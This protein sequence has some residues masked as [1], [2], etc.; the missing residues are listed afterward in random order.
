MEVAL[1]FKQTEVG[2]VPEDWEVKPISALG[3]PVRGASP[4]PAGDPRYFD[5]SYIPW[6]T[7]AAL[8][9]IPPS[10]LVVSKTATKLTEE[11][12]LCSRTLLPGTLIIANSGATLGVAKILGIKCCANDGI[13]AVLSIP[14]EVSRRYLVYFINTKTKY[15]REVVASGNGQPNLNTELIGNLRIPLPPTRAEQESIAKVLNDMDIAIDSLE[16]LVLKK[17]HVRQ[18]AMQ[19]LLTGARRLPA[20]SEEWKERTIGEIARPSSERNS[21]QDALTVLACSK[22]SGFVDSLKYFKK[23]V[24]SRD[25][26]GYKVI[27]RGEIGYPANHIEEGSIG[28]QDRYDAALVSPIYVV[29]SVSAEVNSYFL[30]RL[31][32]LES[33]RQKFETATS[34]SVDRRG[35]LRWPT[36]SKLT[37]RIPGVAEQNA[38]A[39]VLMDMDG[40]IA[41]IEARLIKER[42]L[43][44]GIMQELLTGRIRLK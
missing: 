35:S 15:L 20:F 42:H 22:H 10:Q 44:G 6:L 25:T 21:R 37:V 24:F 1:G 29:F 17:R 5:G 36:F 28:L 7:V 19:A 8:T 26:T 27:R 9:N 43:K 16:Q 34:A 38:I 23:Q 12:S 14:K 31:L 32:K 11:G 3:T 2:V 41:E 33:Y 30:H 4:R 18:A 40:E 39:E 13:A